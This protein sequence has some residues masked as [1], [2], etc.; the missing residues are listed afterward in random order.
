LI[1]VIKVGQLILLASYFLT[2]S[3][4][5]KLFIFL[6]VYL[7]TMNTL[8]LILRLRLFFSLY[9]NPMHYISSGKTLT[10]KHYM[11]YFPLMG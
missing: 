9:F 4:P 10:Q 6:L 5:F 8:R 3:L 2:Q 1:Q 11:P 7:S